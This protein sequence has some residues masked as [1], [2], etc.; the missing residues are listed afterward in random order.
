[1]NNTVVY[2]IT[3]HPDHTHRYYM[4]MYGGQDS[5]QGAALPSI[6][7]MVMVDPVN[8]DKFTGCTDKYRYRGYFW[9]TAI[10]QIMGLSIGRVLMQMGWDFYNL[11]D[12]PKSDQREYLDSCAKSQ[13]YATAS[14]EWLELENSCSLLNDINSS[15]TLPLAV[16]SAE[17]GIRYDDVT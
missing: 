17:D 13:H 9:L 16:L 6:S 14:L 15:Y 8:P 3:R 12:L 5:V 2:V 7:G 1:M 4:H 10:S 11:Y